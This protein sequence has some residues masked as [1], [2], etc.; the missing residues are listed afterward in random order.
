M[1]SLTEEQKRITLE[2]YKEFNITD[3]KYR[4]EA[5][6]EPKAQPWEE[7]CEIDVWHLALENNDYYK[8]YG[9]WA[10][11]LLVETISKRGLK[12]YSGMELI[13]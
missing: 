1:D 4:L 6:L 5:Y 8:N 3:D 10:N 7:E 2:T 13:E 12:E 11:G 9:I